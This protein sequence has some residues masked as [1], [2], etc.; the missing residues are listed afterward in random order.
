M[1]YSCMPSTT[2]FLNTQIEDHFYWGKYNLKQQGILCS[3]RRKEPLKSPQVSLHHFC[4]NLYHC[5][6][7]T[8]YSKLN[9]LSVSSFASWSLVLLQKVKCSIWTA[10]SYQRSLEYLRLLRGSIISILG[11]SDSVTAEPGV[12]PQT[13]FEVLVFKSFFVNSTV[14]CGAYQE[15]KFSGLLTA[16][17]STALPQLLSNSHTQLDCGGLWLRSWASPISY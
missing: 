11:Q 4:F 1:S 14:T 12:N 16:A 3:C 10:C 7:K 15:N 9:F 13:S 8:L 2:T 5:K 17:F 6:T